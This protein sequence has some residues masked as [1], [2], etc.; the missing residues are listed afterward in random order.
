[1]DNQSSELLEKIRQQFESAPYPKNPLEQSPKEDANFLFIHNLVTAHYLR[2][3]EVIETEG[4]VLLDAGCGTG[5][6]SLVLAEANP[7]AKIIGID[8]SEESIKLADQRL[9]YHGFEN[10]EFH[11]LSIEDIPNLNMKFDFINADEVLYLLPDPILGLQVMKSALNSEGIIRANFH[12]SRQRFFY[13]GAQE[14]FKSIGLMDDNPQELE[15]ELVRETMRSLKD[16]VLLKARTWK[17]EFEADSQ[18]VISNYLLQ[19]DKGYAIPEVFSAL[20]TADLEFISMVHWRQ[21]ELLDLFKNPNNLPALIGMSLQ[22]TTIEEQLQL[23]ELLHPIHRLIDFWCG[24]PNH[25]K[26][27]V[28]VLEW[29]SADWVSS[30]VHLHP[31]LRV[32]QV[33]QDLINC[34]ARQRSW[35][36]SRYVSASTTVPIELEVSMAAAC[37]LP[38]WEGAKPFTSLVERWLK[39]RPLH[40]VTLEPV[41]EAAAF[42]EVKN[43]LISLEAFLYV[44]LQRF[45]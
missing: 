33:K 10:A 37:L 22:E 5:Y 7:G 12:S 30:Q 24:H 17:S 34:I 1:M 21:W 27:F 26:H 23:F 11:I 16:G 4:K 44:L 15:I 19:G 18:P 41:S 25:V 31:Q 35:E 28:P 13:Y 3:Q 2:N 29:T 40:P 14:F 9:R 8:L 36:I 20:K 32:P 38:L 45:T 43:F 42:D 39:V 6:T